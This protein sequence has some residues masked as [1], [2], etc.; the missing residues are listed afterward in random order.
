[1]ILFIHIVLPLPQRFIGNQNMK[2]RFGQEIRNFNFIINQVKTVEFGAPG[3][4]VGLVNT[5][6]QN[7]LYIALENFGSDLLPVNVGVGHR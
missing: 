1:M 7:T 3:F 2:P 4:E 5:S 6:N